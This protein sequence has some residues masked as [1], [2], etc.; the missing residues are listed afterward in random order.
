MAGELSTMLEA[1]SKDLLETVQK[2]LNINPQKIGQYRQ[3]L[4]S[5]I[6]IVAKMISNEQ[7]IAQMQQKQDNY[8]KQIMSS[9]DRYKKLA[10]ID[11]QIGDLQYNRLL[12]DYADQTDVAKRVSYVGKTFSEEII[13][14]WQ[15]EHE[16]I[17]FLT[18]G[19]TETTTYAIY[20]DIETDIEGQD[21]SGNFLRGELTAT[22]FSKV[23]NVAK[24]GSI[25]LKK[26]D[27][28]KVFQKNPN[29]TKEYNTNGVWEQLTQLILGNLLERLEKWHDE[30]R[31]ID[32]TARR[33]HLGRTRFKQYQLLNQLFGYKDF[34]KGELYSRAGLTQLYQKYTLH[35]NNMYYGISLSK[36][37]YNRGHIAEAFERYLATQN[38]KDV[39][40]GGAVP[41]QDD[42]IKFLNESVGNLPWFAGGDVLS[43]KTQVKS[44]FGDD[45]TSVQVASAHS[46][47][48]LAKELLMVLN[49][50]KEW[51]QNLQ[52]KI[53]NIIKSEKSNIETAFQKVSDDTIA[54]MMD[55]MIQGSV[56]GARKKI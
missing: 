1:F 14:L 29:K 56:Y 25:I 28:T 45:G 41:S 8:R 7:I 49:Y 16:I 38:F 34:D 31:E 27:V 40:E 33:E 36:M 37:P 17:N 10:N 2:N 6:K 19:K 30:L 5:Q 26:T 43:T 53:N 55:S 21:R 13:K 42:L 18:D 4:T 35:W 11:N 22:E 54:N 20:Y 46:L 39:S 9:E 3:Q 50:S 44:L 24:D 12:K 47:Y 23:V 32:D 48:N 51:L 52:G 15:L